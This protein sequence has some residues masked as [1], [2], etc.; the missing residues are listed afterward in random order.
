MW[1]GD[2][3]ILNIYTRI[4]KVKSSRCDH[5][6]ILR[7]F[8]SFFSW[9]LNNLES[10]LPLIYYSRSEMSVYSRNSDLQSTALI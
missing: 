8:L 2:K 4:W 10:I 5:H 9:L 7:G 1:L 3:N 6:Q